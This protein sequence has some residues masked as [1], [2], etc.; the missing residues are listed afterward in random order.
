MGLTRFGLTPGSLRP[1]GATLGFMSG[2]SVRELKYKGRWEVESSLGVYIQEATSHL[3]VCELASDEI[4]ALT[5]MLS[6]C[7]S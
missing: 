1:A 7:D 5:R 4:H 6:V 3:C 2:C